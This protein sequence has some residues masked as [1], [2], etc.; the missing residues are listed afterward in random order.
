MNVA[1]RP[2]SVAV[3]EAGIGV[4]PQHRL[5]GALVDVHDL[6]CLAG[7]FGLTGLTHGLDL[8]L[9]LLERQIKK[10]LLPRRCANL[11]T[12]ALIVVS[13]CIRSVGAPKRFTG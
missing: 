12:E 13:P 2:M 9:A 3:D 5:Y 11:G 10:A 8:P 1:G 4:L 6:R 7:L